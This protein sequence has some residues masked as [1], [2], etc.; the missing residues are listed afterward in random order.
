MQ[1]TR[2]SILNPVSTVTA[3]SF[4]QK[5]TMPHCLN[6]S[7]SLIEPEC[8][9]ETKVTAPC[10]ETPIIPFWVVWDLY[11]ENISFC[12]SKDEGI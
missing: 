11:C 12:K 2:S 10:G 1:G 7:L 8:N 3:I 9:E 4:S 6:N 5:G